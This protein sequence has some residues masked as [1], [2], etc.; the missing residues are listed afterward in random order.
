MF[1]NSALHLTVVNI[2]LFFGLGLK[3]KLDNNKIHLFPEFVGFGVSVTSERLQSEIYHGRVRP[4][5]DV[6]EVDNVRLNG[7][8]GDVLR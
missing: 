1:I 5:G 6:G 8:S 4:H 2:T 3:F 7:I